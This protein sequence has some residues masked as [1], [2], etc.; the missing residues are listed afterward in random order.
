[1][2]FFEK[3]Y[4]KKY[5][6]NSR[7]TVRRFTVHQFLQAGI[8]VENPDNLARPIN[9]PKAVYQIEENLLKLIKTFGTKEWCKNLEEYRVVSKAVK[10][11]YESE[12]SNS[13]ISVTFGDGKNQIFLSPGGQN[14]LIMQII[15][16]F[17]I[18]CTKGRVL[19]VGDAAEKYKFFDSILS[20]S[21]GINLDIHGKV[22][23]VIIYDEQKNWLFLIEVVTSHGPINGKRMGELVN[24]FGNKNFGLV[25][26]TAF[27]DKRD[28]VKYRDIMGDRGMDCRVTYAYDTL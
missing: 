23:D 7:E 5:T 9:S 6:P 18:Y 19:Y 22:P 3:H 17:K 15:E 28:M 24:L 1:M 4:G 14:N 12:R 10:Q 25:F 27:S 11:Q 26:V 8:I 20:S 2:Y 13:R 21:L 16:E